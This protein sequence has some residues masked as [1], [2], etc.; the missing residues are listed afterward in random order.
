MVGKWWRYGPEKEGK[1]YIYIFGPWLIFGISK[2]DEYNS[3]YFFGTNLTESRRGP[4]GWTDFLGHQ[5]DLGIFSRSGISQKRNTSGPKL[6][7]ALLLEGFLSYAFCSWMDAPWI[8]KGESVGRISQ[9]RALVR[10]GTGEEP[11]ASRA[12]AVED[13]ILEICLALC[14]IRGHVFWAFYIEEIL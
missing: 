2:I 11:W 14:M 1:R 7:G 13:Q 10:Q 8:L 12:P 4:C 3:C 9:E 6:E 5:I